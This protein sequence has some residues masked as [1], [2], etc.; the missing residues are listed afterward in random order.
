MNANA[1]PKK[2]SKVQLKRQ[3]LLQLTTDDLKHIRGGYPGP[4]KGGFAI[5]RGIPADERLSVM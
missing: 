3:P 2:A 1:T 5:S 4:I